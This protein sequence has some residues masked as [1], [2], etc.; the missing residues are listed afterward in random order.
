MSMIPHDGSP[1][2]AKLSASDIRPSVHLPCVLA[3]PRRGVEGGCA[4]R[5]LCRAGSVV[6]H[7]RPHSAV[8]GIA[9][10]HHQCPPSPVARRRPPSAVHS[11]PTRPPRAA[12]RD[13]AAAA[14][15]R[16]PRPPYTAHT[17]HGVDNPQESPGYLSRVRCTCS[18]ESQRIVAL[19]IPL[20]T[21]TNNL[22]IYI[23]LLL[24]KKL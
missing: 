4:E 3:R 15:P 22:F 1:Q 23:I 24:I 9:R 5:N 8:A 14:V 17:T 13:S 10:S 20:G 18:G 6:A 11:P 7:R 21:E 12:S 2:V 16:D 19:S